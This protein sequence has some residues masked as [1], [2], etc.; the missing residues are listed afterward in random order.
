MSSV[1]RYELFAKQAED[2]TQQME[3]LQRLH[4]RELVH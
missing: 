2:T 3:G 4:A 1:Q